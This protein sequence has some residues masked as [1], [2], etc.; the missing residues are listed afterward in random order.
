MASGRELKRHLVRLLFTL[1]RHPR[2]TGSV[3]LILAAVYAFGVIFGHLAGYL[4]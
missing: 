1:F 2:I 3:L 4:L